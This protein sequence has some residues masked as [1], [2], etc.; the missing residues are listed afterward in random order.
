VGKAQRGY[1]KNFV[2]QKEKNE[3]QKSQKKGRCWVRLNDRVIEES[4]GGEETKKPRV[5]KDV[6]ENGTYREKGGG[7]K[8]G[9]GRG[10]FGRGG[11]EMRGSERMGGGGGG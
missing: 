3:G 1:V 2:R 10:G 6:S 11:G 8:G 5:N 7:G 4:A 9:G